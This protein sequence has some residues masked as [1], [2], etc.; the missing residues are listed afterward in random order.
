MTDASFGE[1]SM[2]ARGE[3]KIFQMLDAQVPRLGGVLNV[4]RRVP[5][6]NEKIVARGYPAK[7]IGSTQVEI[8]GSPR[9]FTLLEVL[10]SLSIVAIA[11]TVM[12]QIFSTGL[13][14][15]A[16]AEENSTA[17]LKAEAKMRE[18]IDND[19]LVETSWSEATPDGYRMDVAIIE[20]L[21]ERTINLQVRVMQIA[22]TTRWFKGNKEKT[23]ALKT[24]KT[25]AKVAPAAGTPGA[26]TQ[27]PGSTGAS[28]SSG[29]A[30]ATA[31]GK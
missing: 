12:L 22:L 24:L 7:T 23:L 18:L 15:V 3:P 29:A 11:V 25:M 14:T 17:V 30:P 16:A 10:V 1:L 31:R 26:T 5:P 20:T 13:R 9:G 6:A 8:L 21:K 27:K 19:N 28:T 2:R 4:R